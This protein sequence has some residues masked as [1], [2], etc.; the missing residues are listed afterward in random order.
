MIMHADYFSPSKSRIRIFDDRI[1]FHNPGGL[2]IPLEKLLEIDKSIPR[3]PV[4]AKAFRA[5]KLAETA[6]Y[7]FDKMIDGWKSY[8]NQIPEFNSMLTDFI[9]TFPLGKTVE[10]TRVKTREKTRVKTR[11]KIIELIKDN[12]QITAKELA[13]SLDI[14]I[15]GIEWQLGNLKKEGIIKRIGPA[16]GGHWEIIET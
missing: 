15:K 13:L 14:T 5:V 9:I 11:E 6:G 7:G 16:K 1:E 2:P 3:N 8:K 4:L 10:K 12:N